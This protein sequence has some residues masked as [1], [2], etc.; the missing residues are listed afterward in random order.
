MSKIIFTQGLTIKDTYMNLEIA[1]WL[2]GSVNLN[3]GLYNFLT[4]PY[5][6]YG[7]VSESARLIA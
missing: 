2:S 7:I 1:L 4:K 6:H 5:D 3:S